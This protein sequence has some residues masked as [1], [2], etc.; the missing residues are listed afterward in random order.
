VATGEHEARE[1]RARLQAS[2]RATSVRLGEVDTL[3][4]DVLD[5]S[6]A[7]S[8]ARAMREEAVATFRRVYGAEHPRT[9]AAAAQLVAADRP[10]ARD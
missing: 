8:E 9:R 6:G 7:S 1:A 3:L 4:A 10:R 2:P 5:R